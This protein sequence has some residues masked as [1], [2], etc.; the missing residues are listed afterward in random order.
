MD[1]SVSAHD[2]DRSIIITGNGNHAS[3]RFGSDF[4]LPLRRLQFPERQPR[5]GRDYD[6]LPLLAPDA[7]VIPRI[8]REEIL[9]ELHAWLEGKLELAEKSGQ[10]LRAGRQD[11]HACHQH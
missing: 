9:A 5:A 2:V 4:T 11:P 8:G 1:S 7:G 6:P 10:L 3:I